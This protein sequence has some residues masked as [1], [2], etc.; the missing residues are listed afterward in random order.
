MNA[1]ELKA[2][3]KDIPDDAPVVIAS[4]EEGNSFHHFNAFG[5]GLVEDLDAY[6][7]ELT[8]EEDI[9]EDYGDDA[10]IAMERFTEV[11]IL[12]P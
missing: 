1:G 9:K 2:L 3:L 6:E 4:D 10:D 5:Y 12:W 7:L 8:N 11:F